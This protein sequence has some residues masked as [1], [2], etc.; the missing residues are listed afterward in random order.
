[1]VALGLTEADSI[2]ET[3]KKRLFTD[4][5]DAVIQGKEALTLEDI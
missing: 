5:Y 4:Y 3:R 2:A 1:M